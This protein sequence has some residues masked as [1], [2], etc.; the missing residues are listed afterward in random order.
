[1]GRGITLLR[2]LVCGVKCNALLSTGCMCFFVTSRLYFG[3]LGVILPPIVCRSRRNSAV[4]Q[5]QG[6]GSAFESAD[7]TSSSTRG[8]WHDMI[9]HR[10]DVLNVVRERERQI[11]L[12]SCQIQP[13]QRMPA[14][15]SQRSGQHLPYRCST[16][17]VRSNLSR[18]IIPI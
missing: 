15:P 14:P 3:C 9:N 17:A 13:R 11:L 2:M 16:A 4:I 12:E 7:R 5:L 18:W 1:M 6:I 8:I 10:F